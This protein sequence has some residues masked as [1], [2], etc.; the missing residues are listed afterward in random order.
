MLDSKPLLFPTDFP[1]ISRRSINTLQVN[2]GFKCNQ[3]CNH[4]HVNAG[5]S[6]SEMMPEEVIDDVIH[7]LVSDKPLTLDITGGAPE[8][9]A[10]FKKLVMA[11]RAQQI[12]VLDRCN[13][14]ILSEPGHEELAAFLAANQVEVIA[15]LPCYLEENV[16]QQRGKG[17]FDNS[18]KGLRQ[19]NDLGY[20]REDSDLKLNL[21]YNPVGEHLPP[22]QAGLERDYKKQ[23]SERFGIVFNALFT[24][25]NMPIMRYGSYLQSKG[26][27][28]NYMNLLKQAY[29]PANLETVMCRDLVSI[30]WQGYVYDCDF[31]QMLDMKIIQ[32]GKSLH[33]S[34][35]SEARMKNRPVLVGEH[36][37]GCTAGQGSSCGGAL[38]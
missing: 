32:A 3:S 4:C 11:A 26:E 38:S 37:Y 35:L 16:D 6:R 13:L 19:L 8:L 12:H 27:F 25:T 1:A 10:S 22:A 28:E 9:H 29:Q 17:V 23:L 14:T 20:G 30:D 34:Q 21:V 2:L 7:Y 31:N 24:I 5:P 18:I 15:S 33:I 36:C